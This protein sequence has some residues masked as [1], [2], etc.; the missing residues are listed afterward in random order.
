MYNHDAGNIPT[1]FIVRCS[2]CDRPCCQCEFCAKAKGHT[3]LCGP[4]FRK[5]AV[6]KAQAEQ[7]KK[8]SEAKP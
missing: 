1:V 2:K 5:A 4:C 3:G 6:E 7:V 8:Q